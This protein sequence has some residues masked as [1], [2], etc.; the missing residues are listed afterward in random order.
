MAARSWPGRGRTSLWGTDRPPH[1]SAGPKAAAPAA[2][3]DPD[4]VLAVGHASIV[5]R[6]EVVRGLVERA[7]T[8]PWAGDERAMW[9]S[10]RPRSL[11]GR[12]ITAADQ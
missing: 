12:R 5:T 6:P 3:D 2:D 10:I 11:T 4:H 7:H 9:V 1:A 8:T